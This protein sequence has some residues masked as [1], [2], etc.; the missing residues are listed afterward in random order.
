MDADHPGQQL[1]AGVNE[2]A[3]ATRCLQGDVRA[4]ADLIERLWARGADVTFLVLVRFA[5][6]WAV[7]PHA[8]RRLTVSEFDSIC[9]AWQLAVYARYLRDA[10]RD[11]QHPESD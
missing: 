3:L 11:Q 5:A 7:G 6:P 4:G 2:R 10:R 8:T 9:D 1:A